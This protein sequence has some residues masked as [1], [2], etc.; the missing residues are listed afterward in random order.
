MSCKEGRRVVKEEDG[1]LMGRWVVQDD[2]VA[3]GK[4]RG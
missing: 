1:L 3:K 2:R 4:V